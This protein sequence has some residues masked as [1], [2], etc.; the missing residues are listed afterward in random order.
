MERIEPPKAQSQHRF[1]GDSLT[2]G[3][4]AGYHAEHGRR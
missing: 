3:K 2:A 4:N 1:R